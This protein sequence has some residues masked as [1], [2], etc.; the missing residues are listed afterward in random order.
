MLI[1]HA[2]T[3]DAVRVDLGRVVRSLAETVPVARG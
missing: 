3:A 1:F 2:G